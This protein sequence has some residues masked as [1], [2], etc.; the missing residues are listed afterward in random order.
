MQKVMKSFK[1]RLVPSRREAS[2][3]AQH[4]GASRVVWNC[5]IDYC[6]NAPLKGA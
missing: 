6:E 3:M 2:L 1:F 4:A 5:G